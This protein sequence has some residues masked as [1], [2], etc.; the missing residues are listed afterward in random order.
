M[1]RTV[2]FVRHAKSA[3][4]D[5]VDD[6]D[7]P[8]AARGEREAGLAGAWLRDAVAH[9]DLVLCSTATRARQTCDLLGID[10][11]VKYL[12]ELYDS[13]DDTY[14]PIVGR[15]SDDRDTIV[16]VGHE[17]RIGASIHALAADASSVQHVPTSAMAVIRLDGDWAGATPGSGT[18]VDFH[19]PR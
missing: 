8:L 6:H 5:G 1:T 17:P 7:R 3:Y 10:A 11:P 9:V 12:D 13:P 14:L 15:V 18:L 4:P 16:V 2:I 19:V